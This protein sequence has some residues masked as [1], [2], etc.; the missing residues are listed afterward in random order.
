MKKTLLFLL[1][2]QSLAQPLLANR[3]AREREEAALAYLQSLEEESPVQASEKQEKP[4]PKP[5][6]DAV[7]DSLTGE[8]KVLLGATVLGCLAIAGGL[9]AS[10]AT[11][12]AVGAVKSGVYNLFY[13]KPKPTAWQR[14]KGFTDHKFWE[15]KEK[16]DHMSPDDLK[17]YIDLIGKLLIGGILIASLYVILPELATLYDLLQQPQVGKGRSDPFARRGRDQ[18]FKAAYNPESARQ[19]RVYAEA[20]A[21]A[22]KRA[23]Q[24]SVV[25]GQNAQDQRA[26]QKKAW[27]LLGV[28][29]HSSAGSVLG[30]SMSMPHGQRRRTALKRLL[31]YHPDHWSPSK[32]Y[33]PQGLTATK[34]EIEESTK[35]LNLAWDVFKD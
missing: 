14:F 31:K 3:T 20:W 25:G 32:Q 9:V 24:S 6:R 29:E 13:P 21:K 28:Q 8:E 5:K 35:V 19:A 23:E 33:G 26:L 27:Q 15:Y 12:G 17:N 22:R 4:K 2:L 11:S 18:E 30:V 1:A 16:M 34:V 10:I 7:E